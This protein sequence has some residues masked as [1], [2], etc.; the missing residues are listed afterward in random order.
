MWP[1]SS[2]TTKGR[3]QTAVSRQCL[4]VSEAVW[5]LKVGGPLTQKG[6]DVDGTCDSGHEKLPGGGHEN[7][8]TRIH[9]PRRVP[10][11]RPLLEC[12]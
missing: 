7:C 1:W 12:G 11:L 9:L 6:Y 10:R 3:R 4:A 8:P 2:V 5:C